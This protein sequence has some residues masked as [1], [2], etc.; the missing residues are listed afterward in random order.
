MP[1]QTEPAAGS[2][3][4]H[5]QMPLIDV[6]WRDTGQ[7][8]DGSYTLL[9]H[10]AVTNE[11]TTLYEGKFWVLREQIAPGAFKEVLAGRPDVHFNIGHDMNRAMARTGVR[12]VGELDLSEDARGLRMFAR[13]DPEDPD[14]QSLAVKMKRGIIDQA[15]FAFRVG[16]DELL[17]ETD[18]QGREIETR[19][20]L[21]VSDLFDV[22]V[23]AQGAYAGTDASL[24]SL[25]AAFGRAGFDPA[26]LRPHRA[27]DEAG[28]SQST[29]APAQDPAGGDDLA[30]TRAALARKRRLALIQT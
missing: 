24:R 13:L 16:K 29:I 25:M 26:G 27:S 30:R 9:G 19:T 21:E 4:R 3:I 28:A 22:C 15:S 10:A 17:V 14:V 7:T 2:A 8:G 18:D 6:E 23:C 1:A 12:G 20:I 11:M 5:A